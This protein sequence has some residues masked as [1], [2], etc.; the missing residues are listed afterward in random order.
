MD[1]TSIGVMAG[2]VALAGGL[3]TALNHKHI[4]AHLKSKCCDKETDIDFQLDGSPVKDVEKEI[5]IKYQEPEY[6][7]KISDRI[8]QNK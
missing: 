3:L 2:L 4:R 7:I 1:S 5:P 8:S 6:K